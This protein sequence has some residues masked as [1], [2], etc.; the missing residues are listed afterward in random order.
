MSRYLFRWRVVAEDRSGYYHARWDRATPVTVVASTQDEAWAMACAA[1]G[2]CTRPGSE[3]V[4]F[5]PL[6]GQPA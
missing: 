1:M 2:T 6:Q 3:P 4:G 5:D